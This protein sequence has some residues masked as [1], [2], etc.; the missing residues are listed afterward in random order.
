[1]VSLVLLTGVAQA[2]DFSVRTGLQLVSI[3]SFQ[4][5]AE[6]GLGDFAIGSRFSIGTL[7][8]I[9]SRVQGD[10]YV[11]VPLNQNWNLYAGVGVATF[12][13]IFNGTLNDVH[14]LIGVRLTNG[15][16]FEFV[17]RLFLGTGCDRFANCAPNTPVR[18]IGW[19][20]D[21]GLGFSWRL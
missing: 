3:P 2:Q 13:D 1:M 6:I 16:F 21:F 14:G 5:A 4:F 19:G 17:P 11:V 12:V 15:I 18:P 9:Y 20:I 8:I 7:A 10:V